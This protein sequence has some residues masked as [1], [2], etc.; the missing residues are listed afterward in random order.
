MSEVAVDP[1]EEMV[2]AADEGWLVD[3]CVPSS[4]A[5]PHLLDILHRADEAARGRFGESRAL[6]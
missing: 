2:R 4:N 6:H 3:W 5:I 1:F